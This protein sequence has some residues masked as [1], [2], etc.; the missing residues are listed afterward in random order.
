MKAVVVFSPGPRQVREW[1]VQ[2]ADGTNVEQAIAAS[3][4]LR[5]F[6]ELDIQQASIGIWGRPASLAQIIDVARSA[7]PK[8]GAVVKGVIA[9]L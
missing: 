5:E 7:E 2:L 6:V 1:P 4:L 8:L 3:G 9:R